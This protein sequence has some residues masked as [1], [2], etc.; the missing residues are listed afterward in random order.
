MIQSF[1][2]R[3]WWPREPFNGVSHF[4]GAVLG[5]VGL[6][7]LMVASEGRPWHRAA[8]AIYGASLIV[9]YTA[10]GLFHSLHLDHRRLERLRAFDQVAIYL[11]IAGTYTPVCLVLLRGPVGW[12]LLAVVWAIAL[13]GST[14]RVAWRAKP[15]WLTF[16]L[17]MLMGWLWVVV[18]GPLSAAM[19]PEGLA[20]LFLGGLFYCTGT[21]P[22]IT[23]RPRLW[24]GVFGSHEIWHLCVLGGS[25]CHYVVMFRF[26]AATP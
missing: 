15:E 22:L 19:A 2:K 25:A 11:L 24:P 21:I 12:A 17:Y 7:L 3:R 8:F 5:A 4:G 1:F 10:S 9:L 23:R 14:A 18:I 26:V 16:G 20:W 6:G 13:V